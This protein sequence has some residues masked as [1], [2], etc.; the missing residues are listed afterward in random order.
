MSIPNEEPWKRF[1]GSYVE[2]GIIDAETATYLW[3]NE[4]RSIESL[5]ELP[6]E[7]TKE[8]QDTLVGCPGIERLGKTCSLRSMVKELRN[9]A[10]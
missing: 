6:I 7:N 9:G 4:F 2:R 3:E 10:F 1:Y 8:L 5:D